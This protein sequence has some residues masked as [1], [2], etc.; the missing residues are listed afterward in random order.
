VLA[1]TWEDATRAAFQAFAKSKGASEL[2][3]PAE[4]VIVEA[5]PLLSSG[6]LDFAAVAR[7]IRGRSLSATEG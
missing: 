2:M 7:M 4:V 5:L 1:T 6:K 3:I